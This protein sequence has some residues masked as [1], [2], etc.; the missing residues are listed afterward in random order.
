MVKKIVKRTSI[1]NYYKL[2]YRLN[3]KNISRVTL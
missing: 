1:T 3:S 2:L